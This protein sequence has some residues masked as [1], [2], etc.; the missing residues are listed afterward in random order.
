MLFQPLIEAVPS[1]LPVTVVSFPNSVPASYEQL[2][3][4]V[5]AAVPSHEPF[6]LLGESFSGPLALLMAARRPTGLAGVILCASFISNPT[7]LPRAAGRLAGAWLF[8]L[9][10][11]FVQAKA[12]L[13][14]YSSARL[15]SLLAQAHRQVAPEVMA[16]RIGSVLNVDVSSELAACPVPVAYLRGLHD[17]VVPA[18]NLKQVS[19]C[20]P[21]VRV[22]PIPAPHLVLQVQPQAAAE[23][24]S[25]FVS[26]LDSASLHSTSEE[27]DRG[28]V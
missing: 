3:P 4:T 23:A 6:V 20:S 27:D 5:E 15:R 24:I 17:H 9:T 10:P 28:V 21:G 12:L 11:A 22:Y 26:K 25:D 1:T 16:Q 13:G 8:R 18:R 14:G 19:A 2:L 7:F